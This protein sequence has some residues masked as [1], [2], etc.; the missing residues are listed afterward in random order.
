MAPYDVINDAETKP[1]EVP[2]EQ[3]VEPAAGSNRFNSELSSAYDVIPDLTAG[4]K[5]QRQKADQ[6]LSNNQPDEYC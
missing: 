5:Q 4:Q 1:D 3:E 6:Q 2:P